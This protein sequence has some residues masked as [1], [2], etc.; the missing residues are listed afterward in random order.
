[1]YR[2]NWNAFGNSFN[3]S[4]TIE[5]A[6]FMRDSGLLAAGYN[7]IT[8]GGM[9][10]AENGDPEAVPGYPNIPKQNITRNVSGY[11]QVDPSRFP[12]PVRQLRHHF[13]P[14]DLLSSALYHPARAAWCD[15]VGDRGPRMLI[16]ACNPMLCPNWGSRHATSARL[17]LEHG[18]DV[19]YRTPV[20][21]CTAIIMAAQH[22]HEDVVG[23]LLVFGAA[24]AVANAAGCTARTLSE[25]RGHL[26]VA[27]L[28][29]SVR[30]WSAIRIA[31]G[32]RRHADASTA[33]R[34][35]LIDPA[36]TAVSVLRRTALLAPL[37]SAA[38]AVIVPYA[39]VHDMPDDEGL[40][41]MRAFYQTA[42]AATARLVRDATSGWAPAV[43]RLYHRGF[44]A[45][46][47]LLLL[48]SQRQRSRPSVRP[49]RD[50]HGVPG[51]N[52]MPI[53]STI[54]CS[55]RTL[56]VLPDELWRQ[57]LRCSRRRDWAAAAPPAG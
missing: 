1:M 33:L 24:A 2:Q 50:A 21:G 20:V 34:L 47:R 51:A 38:A 54:L 52:S 45:M 12:G 31:V 10:Y 7:Y 32:L 42:N 56:P 48:V 44:R 27:A 35:G 5:V 15:L 17:L 43:H 26:T 39:A 30:G 40:A 41:A 46:V 29:D 57:V 8:L 55:T 3:A 6:H 36:D 14:V 11:L 23:L 28:L 19:N 25:V 53:S 13:G 9:G 16:G 49:P 18:A 37:A 22:G 4:L